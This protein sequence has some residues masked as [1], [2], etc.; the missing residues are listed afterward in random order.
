[1]SNENRDLIDILND[2]DGGSII[3]EMTHQVRC[4]VRAARMADKKAVVTL[5]IEIEPDGRQLIVTP[6]VDAKMPIPA[7]PMTLFFAN[8]DGDLVKSD[9]KQEELRGIERA[10]N[11][12]PPPLRHVTSI[13]S[14]KGA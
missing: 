6:K 7:T 9:P 4:A 5:K 13:D 2:L 14:N 3:Q 11:R 12:T 1:M 10:V 8:D